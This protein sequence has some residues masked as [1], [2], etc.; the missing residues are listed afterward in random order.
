MENPM[1]DEYL[2]TAHVYDLL[3]SLPLRP[4]RLNIRSFIRDKSHKRI[5]DICC[6]TGEQLRI[7]HQADHELTGIDLSA[8]MLNQARKKSPE[9]ITYL[10]MDGTQM[11]FEP[12]SFDCAI[13][14]FALHEKEKKVHDRIFLKGF[15][16]VRPG[17]HIVLCDFCQVADTL[18]SRLFGRFLLPMVEKS[19]GPEHFANYQSWMQQGALEG[20]FERHNHQP[21]LI[22]S[23]FKGCVQL[24]SI[25]K[26]V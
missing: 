2:T 8:A 22:S 5:L 14:S 11:N 7:L 23:H 24:C 3:L 17:G 15:Q 19:A 20:F 13:I 6:G 4:I 12:E 21:D 18:S 1:A 26:N 16:M 25:K 10:C 9:A